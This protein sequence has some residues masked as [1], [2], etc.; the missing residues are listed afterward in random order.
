MGRA[1]EKPHF[2]PCLEILLGIMT[3]GI[4]FC[5]RQTLAPRHEKC[6]QVLILT[7]KRVVLYTDR[8]CH[9]SVPPT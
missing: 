4:W 9:A 7:N 8:T 5:V 6:S 1:L 2:A 3:L